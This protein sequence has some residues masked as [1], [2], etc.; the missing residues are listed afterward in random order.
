MPQLFKK[1]LTSLVIVASFISS[2]SGCTSFSDY[3]RNG[4]KVGPSYCPPPAPVAQ[5]WID[6]ADIRVRTQADDISCWW[7]VFNDPVLNNLI[8]TAYRQNLTVKQAGFRVLQA[9]YLLAITRGEMFPQ[10][11]TLSGSYARIGAGQIFS[12]R[13]STGFSLGWELDFWG[14]FRRAILAAEDTLDASVADYDNVMVTLLSDVAQ[15]YVQIRTNEEQIRLLQA[16]IEFQREV[17]EAAKKFVVIGK[18]E[19]LDVYQA[20]STLKQS[21]AGISQLQIDMRQAGNRLCVLLGMPPVDIERMLGKGTIPT[22]PPEVAVGIPA[23]LIRRRPD[24][25]RA[26]AVAMAQGEQIGIAQAE[27]YPA[28]SINGNLGYTASN[29]SHLFTSQSFVGS[30]GPSFNWAI[31]NYGRLVNNVRYQDARFYELVMA[32]QNTVLTANEE[33]E[34]GIVTFLRAQERRKMLDDSV[35]AGQIA[36]DIV[37]RK[38]GKMSGYDF[39][40]L[41]VIEQ[42]FI[43]QQNAWA[44]AQGQIAQGLIQIYRAMGGGWEIR[45]NPPP[46]EQGFVPVALPLEEP[47]PAVPPMP[48][49][50]PNPLPNPPDAPQQ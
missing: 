43:T 9:R 5:R 39:N 16:N 21:E 4:F 46:E 41:A 3:V 2:L 36:R 47:N 42:N 30:V 25:R 18:V 15:N 26:E 19:D 40:R 14:R 33:V 7:T 8:A 1:R 48:Q 17:W 24:V 32:Y 49:E 12:D 37:L 38:Y 13:W 10:S 29:F 11:Q 31:L 20:E 35:K 27:L 6:Q 44:Q 45:N 28:F 50:A 22:A 23:N 34:N